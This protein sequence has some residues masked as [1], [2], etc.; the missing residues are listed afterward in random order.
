M[1]DNQN[2]GLGG[3]LGDNLGLHTIKD[4]DSNAD[5]DFS[6]NDGDLPPQNNAKQ[7]DKQMM[8]MG[9]QN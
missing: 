3:G 5:S 6:G 4:E 7:S 8:N 2:Q 1:M 9:Y